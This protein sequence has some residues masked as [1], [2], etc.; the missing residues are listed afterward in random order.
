MKEFYHSIQKN[1]CG[2][3]GEFVK[4]SVYI[5]MNIYGWINEVKLRLK[6]YEKREAF[7]ASLFS[8]L[9][10]FQ[11]RHIAVVPRCVFRILWLPQGICIYRPCSGCNYLSIPVFRLSD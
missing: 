8:A 4:F 10:S 7:A 9:I 3:E 5:N 11:G 2:K 1:K 6:G